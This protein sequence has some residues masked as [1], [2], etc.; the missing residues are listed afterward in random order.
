[1]S[2]FARQTVICIPIGRSLFKMCTYSWIYDPYQTTTLSNFK[3]L[4]PNFVWYYNLYLEEV[5]KLL[6]SF[7]RFG[8]EECELCEN[9]KLY[10]PSRT[11][12]WSQDCT[13]WEDHIKTENSTKEQWK[14]HKEQ[15][16]VNNK[17]RSS[18]KVDLQNFTMLPRLEMFQSVIFT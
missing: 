4:N 3:L 15:E 11:G 12:H 18:S 13:A 10:K 2:V 17:M 6:I 5:I 1:M 16:S 8:H 7:V 14:F 9:Y